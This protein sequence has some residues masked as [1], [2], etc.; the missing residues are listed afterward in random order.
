MH[1]ENRVF[2]YVYYGGKEQWEDLKAVD[3]EILGHAK[4]IKQLVQNVVRTA[5]YRSNQ[6]KASQFIAENVIEKKESF[7][8]FDL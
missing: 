7:D 4:C 8:S 5:K 3:K 1:A 6:Q 2:C